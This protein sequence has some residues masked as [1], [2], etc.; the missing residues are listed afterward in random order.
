MHETQRLKR[1]P[2]ENKLHLFI[3]FFT[4]LYLKTWKNYW[5]KK[6]EASLIKYCCDFLQVVK[7]SLCQWY[8]P[9]P[10]VLFPRNFT[11]QFQANWAL[12]NSSV[13]CIVWAPY[14][15]SASREF[16]AR[17]GVVRHVSGGTRSLITIQ[18][19][20]ATAANLDSDLFKPSSRPA[21]GGVVTKQQEVTVNYNI[22][23]ENLL[24][25]FIIQHS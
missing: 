11:E 19:C 22:H 15:V 14:C 18:V 8:F 10:F 21:V 5:L 25:A 7:L 17:S 9:F 23:V 3:F 20:E 24:E 2:A 16:N 12:K 6:S 4:Q 1:V 13:S